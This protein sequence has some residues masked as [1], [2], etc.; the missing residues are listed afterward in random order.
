MSL[1]ISQQGFDIAI[2]SRRVFL[3]RKNVIIT[4]TFFQTTYLTLIGSTF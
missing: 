4:V 3:L 1:S 2:F